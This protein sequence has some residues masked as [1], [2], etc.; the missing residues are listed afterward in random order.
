MT[1][2][3][4]YPAADGQMVRM[5]TW[6]VF[7]GC[8]FGC[9]YCVEPKSR[10]LMADLSLKAIGDVRV[11]DAVMGFDE[12]KPSHVH[13]KLSP[14]TVT[15]VFN[16]RSTDIYRLWGGGFEILCSGQHP[17]LHE[18]GTWSRAA[19]FA[20]QGSSLRATTFTGNSKEDTELYRVGYL[21]GICDGDA[22]FNPICID[23]EHY[24][25]FRLALTDF[26]PLNY[27]QAV[28]E[29]YGVS[30]SRHPFS[31]PGKPMEMLQT[32]SKG[33]L[34]AIA[35]LLAEDE[36]QTYTEYQRGYLSG[37]FDAEGTY[38]GYLRIA[39]Y[40]DK[41]KQKVIEF[42]RLAGFPFVDEPRGVRL[43][44]GNI[45]RF[46]AYV[47]PKILR[48]I[49]S[50]AGNADW[51]RPIS[52]Q[53][54][55]RRTNQ[56][57]LELV[58]LETTTSTYIVEGLASHN[59]WARRRAETR[60][61]HLARFKDGFKPRLNESELGRRFKPGSMVF[62]AAMGEVAFSTPEEFERIL[63]VIRKNP[64]TKFLFCTK[65]PSTYSMMA[66]ETSGFPDNV[67][68]GATIETTS[69]SQFGPEYSKAPIPGYRRE[70]LCD[71]DHPHKFV[72]IEPIMDLDVDVMVQWMHFIKP[73][74]VE[75]GADNYKHF[76]IEPSAEKVNQLLTRLRRFVPLV[77]EKEGLE[78]LKGGTA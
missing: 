14:A 7:T 65:D 26:E 53:A 49:Q 20:S 71:V 11:G 5:E 59:C 41:I 4:T 15:A 30:V 61:K 66:A 2:M 58:N 68:L 69:Y 77:V 8:D 39:N 47:K 54:E 17:W 72:S 23:R 45:L 44:G 74:I 46:L 6:N 40:D 29:D 35:N 43:I 64:K 12:S 56:K 52:V 60:M 51:S 48:K 37:I 34:S 36:K 9:S 67:V 42:G 55:K 73:E 57:G 28:L 76:L 70:Y 3:F 16:R 13:R 32:R 27:V 75:V 24:G 50:Y 10:V 62:V 63:Q 19:N 18:R 22:T 33:K 38:S 78:R 1:R 21:K 31:N 25:W